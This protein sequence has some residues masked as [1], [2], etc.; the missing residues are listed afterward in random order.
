MK[1]NK[2]N[3]KNSTDNTKKH[4]WYE[5]KYLGYAYME[6]D[7]YY[8]F[9]FDNPTSGAWASYSLRWVADALDEINKEWDEIIS[10]IPFVEN[11]TT[12]DLD[13]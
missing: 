2:I 1:Q 9:I 4:F 6:V 7:G 5:G 13:F 12:G 3:I 10:K 11:N 8:V